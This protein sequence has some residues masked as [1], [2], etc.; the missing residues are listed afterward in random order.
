LLEQVLDSHPEITSA[1]E[2]QIFYE[3]AFVP[4]TRGRSPASLSLFPILESASPERLRQSRED[5][6]R[7][8]ES[9]IGQTV[10]ERLLIDKNPSL[11]TLIPAFV[12]VFP[13]ARFLVALR[14][15]RD[16]CLSCFMQPLFPTGPLN[17]TYPSLEAAATQYTSMM[18]LWQ[19]TKP[20]MPCP[21]LEIRYEDL[22]DNL[23]SVARHTLEFLGVSWDER[24][25]T[26]QQ[27]TRNKL[28]RSPTY[29]DVKRPISKGAIGRWRHYQKYFE[30]YLDKLEPF[31]KA[32]GYA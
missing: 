5:Y 12:R 24:V 26:F 19:T 17:S 29:G 8:T 21:F 20:L 15:P 25:L 2:T 3:E 13:E 18:S 31:V 30:P 6:F 10:G 32:F 1:E 9:F 7:Y 16:V 23:E 4:L 28:V 14:D 22:T 11:T 27:H